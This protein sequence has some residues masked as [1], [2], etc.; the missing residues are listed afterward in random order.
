M[1]TL[2]RKSGD[3]SSG[4]SCTTTWL[5][6]FEQLICILW[7]VVSLCVNM[8]HWSEIM[9]KVAPALIVHSPIQI[10]PIYQ[11]SLILLYSFPHEVKLGIASEVELKTCL[12]FS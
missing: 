12:P 10:K 7:A 9:P 3:W 2:D 5:F 4:A 11:K 6:G 8:E 1:S